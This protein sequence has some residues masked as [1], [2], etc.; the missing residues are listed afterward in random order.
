MSVSL[1]S[2]FDGA[3]GMTSAANGVV[4]DI[5]AFVRVFASVFFLPTSICVG[6]LDNWF[7]S[8]LF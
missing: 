4:A 6:V 2:R 7:G 8:S 5:F 1:F 3:G